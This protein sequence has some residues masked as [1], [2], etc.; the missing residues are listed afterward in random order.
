[1]ESSLPP[2]IPPRKSTPSAAQPYPG[3]EPTKPRGNGRGWILALA[4][5]QTIGAFVFF[6]I[7]QTTGDETTSFIVLAVTLGLAAI[8]FGLW[9]WG[10]KAPF[11]AILTALI[12]FITFHLLDAVLDPMSLARGIIVKIAVLVGLSSALKTAYTKKREAELEAAQL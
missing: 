4:I 7:A 3:A 9:I 1:M 12:V 6:A 5:M 2:A 8:Y 11:A 10:K